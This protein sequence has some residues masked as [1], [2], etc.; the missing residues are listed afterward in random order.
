MLR[1]FYES[2]ERYHP[3]GVFDMYQDDQQMLAAIKEYLVCELTPSEMYEK[4]KKWNVIVNR[5]PKN[6]G[7][8]VGCGNLPPYSSAFGA[9]PLVDPPGESPQTY[10]RSHR[11]FHFDTICPEYAANPTIVGFFG[12]DVNELTILFAGHRYH[13]IHFEDVAILPW[14]VITYDTLPFVE[15]SRFVWRW[16][17]DLLADD[18]YIIDSFGLLPKKLLMF[19]RMKDTAPYQESMSDFLKLYEM[20]AF[21]VLN[22]LNLDNSRDNLLS[23]ESKEWKYWE[24]A[25]RQSNPKQMSKLYRDFFCQRS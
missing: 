18:G 2:H 19:D 4:F 15:A 24:T 14:D 5:K 8:V 20:T 22:M 23:L 10:R 1:E 6:G 25:L 21:D 17:S 16:I 12:A 7:L 3:N 13:L 11:H 9:I